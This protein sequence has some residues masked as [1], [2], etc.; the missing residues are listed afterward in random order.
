[1]SRP[2]IGKSKKRPRGWHKGPSVELVELPHTGV[3]A[4]VTAGVPVP[5]RRGEQRNGR[6]PETRTRVA[7]GDQP[8]ATYNRQTD[9][10][11]A[12]SKEV[13]RGRR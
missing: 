2:Q 8:G 10:H 4:D 7:P 5:V 11:G 1:M 12:H 3:N 9:H 13:D 6:R